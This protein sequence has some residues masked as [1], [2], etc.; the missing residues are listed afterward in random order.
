MKKFSQ[1]LSAVGLGDPVVTEVEQFW[2]L[3]EPRSMVDSFM[4][5]A[6][7]ARGL[8]LAQTDE[9]RQTVFDAIARGMAQFESDYG[10]FRV[11][12]P[13]LIGSGTK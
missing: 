9:V 1:A 5:G 13:A 4:Q 8:M 7:R 6:V 2:A 11:P 12:M 10:G 3:E